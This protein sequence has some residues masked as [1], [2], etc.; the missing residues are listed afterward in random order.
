M[1]YKTVKDVFD[2]L[3]GV[4]DDVELAE[5]MISYIGRFMTK[6]VEHS[7]FFGGV[8]LGVHVVR[9]TPVDRSQFLEYF[10]D[11]E[12]ERETRQ[13]IVELDD[14]EKE[15]FVSTDVVN[16]ALIWLM[17]RFENA[18]GN[19]ELFR[20]AKYAAMKMA[21]FKH[22]TAGIKDRFPSPT[23]PM[24]ALSLYESLDR[25]SGLKR[26]G[27]WNMNIEA[28]AH[29]FLDN[30][31]FKDVF[32]TMDN[33]R[34]VVELANEIWGSINKMLNKLTR[35]FHIIHKARSQ[36]KSTSKIA[37]VD[38]EKLLKDYSSKP[39]KLVEDMIT[40]SRDQNSFIKEELVDS[41]VSLGTLSNTA[42]KKVLIYYSED[43]LSGKLHRD[44]QQR[45]ILY[46][47]AA[48]K[49]EKISLSDIPS[50]TRMVG[51]VF[52][53][54]RTESKEIKELKEDLMTIVSKPLKGGRKS[55]LESAR[56]S[57]FL[58]VT[59]R[60]LTIQAFK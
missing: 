15:Y 40:I 25:R 42:L 54:S 2:D 39:R 10:L 46:F 17:N 21:M 22:L 58:Y 53:G 4:Q 1:V 56:I 44:T 26:H 48:V 27:S 8:S 11:I 37:N 41:V 18:N 19:T 50:V 30:G 29:T 45:I 31:V 60:T 51:N 32:A 36:I 59:L 20:Q 23:D 6:N 14:I 49:S 52:R 34:R 33:N 47:L 57:L 9:F 43:F 55:L 3:I 13:A 28:K 5:G 16:L 7:E 24:V 35:E 38:G 12:D